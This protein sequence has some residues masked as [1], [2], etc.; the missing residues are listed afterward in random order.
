[1]PELS[2]TVVLSLAMTIKGEGTAWIG[3]APWTDEIV[4]GTSYAECYYQ[5]VALRH[6]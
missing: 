4:V 3:F 6:R 5:L 2:T 1:M